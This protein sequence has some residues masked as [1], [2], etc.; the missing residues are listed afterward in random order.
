MNPRDMG[1]N[2]G[3]DL[4]DR[5]V[6]RNY[7]GRAL[8]NRLGGIGDSI[9]SIAAL[10]KTRHA[11]AEPAQSRLVDRSQVKKARGFRSDRVHRD[12]TTYH[13]DVQRCLRRPRQRNRIELCDQFA[14]PMDGVWPPEVAP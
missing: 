10:D 2:G 11:I 6:G 8:A 14:Q 13:A 7:A 5:T 4:D 1:R 3:S 12:A 9:P